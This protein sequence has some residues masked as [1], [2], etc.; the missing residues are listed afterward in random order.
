MR[1]NRVPRR[2]GR[3][4]TLWSCTAAALSLVWAGAFLIPAAPNASSHSVAHGVE[5]VSLSGSAIRLSELGGD[6]FAWRQSVAGTGTC[7]TVHLV[8]NGRPLAIPVHVTRD[9]F[10]ASVPL[11]PGR[12]VIVARCKQRSGGTT[13]SHPVI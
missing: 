13:Q 10:Q 3:R 8:R 2:V 12:N 9:R 7:R 6:V 1:N 5:Y 4:S 11:R